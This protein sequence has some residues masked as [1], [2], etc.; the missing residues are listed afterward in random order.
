[1]VLSATHRVRNNLSADAQAGLMHLLGPGKL[2]NADKDDAAAAWPTTAPSR[3]TNAASQRNA[4]T[5]PC[6]CWLAA[7]PPHGTQTAIVVGPAVSPS[8][9]TAMVASVQFHWQRGVQSSHR[10]SHPADSNAPGDATAGTWVRVAQAWAGANWG[11]AF[12]PRVGQEVVVAFV[13]GDIDRPIVVGATC[14]GRALP[15]H[16]AIK[17]GANAWPGSLVMHKPAHEGH[18]PTP[19]LAGIKTQ[20]LD[21][22]QSGS[23]GF[24]QLVMD[25]TIPRPCAGTHHPAPDLAANGPSAAT[26]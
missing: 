17:S 22:S 7:S 13:E 12:I 23:G 19:P 1:M 8:T 4:P 25:N 18:A 24:N 15:M 14:N 16:K 21:A 9:P 5:C 11:G 3:C 2:P 6:A 10:L 26:A 20:A